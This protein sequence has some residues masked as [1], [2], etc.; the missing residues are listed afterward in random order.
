MKTRAALL[1][2]VGEAFSVE[3][4]DLEG[5]KA[6]EVLVKVAATGVCHSDHHIVT[7]D[8]PMAFP[9]LA[10]HEGA[11]IVE[12]VGPGVTSV[13][14]GDHVVMS[15]IP[16]CGHCR[17]C[18]TGRTNLCDLGAGLLVGAQLDGT[19]RFSVDGEDIAQVCMLGT[20]AEYTVVAEASVVK[21]P[22]D[23]P[24]ELACLVGCGVPTGYGAAVH[25]G[26]VSPGEVVVVFGIGGIGINA[27]QGA[28]IAGARA[29]IAVD[30]EPLKR[31]TALKL[32]AT[33][34][35]DPSE[36]DPIDVVQSL[37]N[38]QGG[39]VAILTPG[40]L[41][42][43]LIGK[44]AACVS[45]GGRV[46]CVAVPSG[47]DL[48]IEV[49]PMEL[50]LFEKELIGTV[51]GGCNPFAEINLLLELN[52]TGK[53]RLEELITNR[54]RLDDINAAFAD[55]LEGRNIRGVIVFD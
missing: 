19:Y 43:A 45:K 12:E 13:E 44:G 2:G 50:V 35:V 5:P 48:H 52:R 55:M 39:D 28:A 16:S 29:V 10:G 41:T 31:E 11:G 40:L 4:V 27:V 8:L 46:V 1:R 25:R 24:L 14:P 42:P 26:R 54:Y 33:H 47:A 37:T 23:I 3:E 22:S 21:I 49:P 32:G 18:A 34:V 20:F 38:G 7:G 51:Y 53:L 17:W 9:V 15:F 36:V 6:N 30:P